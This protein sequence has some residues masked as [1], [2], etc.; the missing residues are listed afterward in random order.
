MHHVHVMHIIFMSSWPSWPV[1]NDGPSWL[2][3][4]DGRSTPLR[5][6]RNCSVLQ[7]LAPLVLS[8]L[9]SFE[10]RHSRVCLIMGSKS[11]S[12]PCSSAFAVNAAR[13]SSVFFCT[14]SWCFRDFTSAAKLACSVGGD[15]VLR[16][17]Q[18]VLLLLP[19]CLRFLRLI[20]TRTPKYCDERG[21]D[22]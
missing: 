16:C 11:C 18:L 14:S 20:F 5:Q 2:A 15:V 10:L 4:E 9:H 8:V 13:C 17:I 1:D 22:Y 19:L 7:A 6:W 3:G 21:L 12:R